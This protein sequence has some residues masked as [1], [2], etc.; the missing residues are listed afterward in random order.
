MNPAPR[1]VG[2]ICQIMD[3]CDVSTLH[4]CVPLAAGSCREW[5]EL[6]KVDDFVLVI[7]VCQHQ[8]LDDFKQEPLG[9]S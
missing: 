2:W 9:V 1:I 7:L 6:K 4:N 8:N 3:E 5:S